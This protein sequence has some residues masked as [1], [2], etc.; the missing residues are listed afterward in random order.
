MMPR[1][2]GIAEL[3][4]DSYE[5]LAFRLS[6][7]GSAATHQGCLIGL[8]LAVSNRADYASNSFIAAP[9]SF[10][11]GAVCGPG[12]LRKKNISRML[13]WDGR[14]HHGLRSDES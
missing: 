4:C 2:I 12:F 10:I 14:P 3:D 1:Q 6:L 11:S 7:K 8:R 9:I 13:S 5:Y